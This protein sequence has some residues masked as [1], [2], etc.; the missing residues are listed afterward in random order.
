MHYSG[1]KSIVA[2]ATTLRRHLES[3]HCN[4]YRRWAAK[5]GFPSALPGDRRA[6]AATEAAT[7]QP[8]LKA[9]LKEIPPKEVIIPYSDEAFREAAIEWLIAT[10]QPIDALEHPKFK[11]MIDISARAKDGVRIPGRK[12]TRVEIINPFKKRLGQLKEKF[13]VDPSLLY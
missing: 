11:E 12:S 3:D 6:A 8:T 5:E 4:T 9:H 1:K 13:R 10:D 2:Q 7:S